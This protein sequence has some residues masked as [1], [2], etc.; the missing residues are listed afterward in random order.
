LGAK[1]AQGEMAISDSYVQGAWKM[2]LAYLQR[3]I[4]WLYLALA[5]VGLWRLGKQGRHWWLLLFWTIGSFLAYAILDVSR[6]FWYYVSL[7]PGVM[8]VVAAGVYWVRT[9]VAR[10]PAVK[11]YRNALAIILMAVLLWPSMSGLRYAQT[12][13]DPRLELYQTAGEWLH[14]YTPEQ[15]SV[16]ALE[17]GILGYYAQRRI[18]D[19]AG[20]LQPHVQAQ[21]NQKST[22]QDTAQWAIEQYRPAYLAVYDGWFSDAQ[23]GLLAACQVQ[24]QFPQPRGP[25]FT[26]YKCDWTN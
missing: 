15:A 13:P 7:T 3:P 11:R 12:H 23:A 18:V 14:E 5:G 6:Y 9:Q 1:Q 21:M 16:G 4:Y 26:V 10:W 2:L 19:F 17:I 8:L 24:R 22:Y 25:L 20:L